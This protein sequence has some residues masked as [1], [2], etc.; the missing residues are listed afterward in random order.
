M[1]VLFSHPPKNFKPIETGKTDIAPGCASCAAVKPS[2][3]RSES[4]RNCP[5]V[6]GTVSANSTLT[7]LKALLSS[8]SD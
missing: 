8:S 1:I 7:Y 6:L 4:S 3:D 5:W 2:F